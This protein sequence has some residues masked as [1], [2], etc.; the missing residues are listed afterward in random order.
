M[1]DFYGPNLLPGEGHHFAEIPRGDEFHGNGPEHR[2]QR[3]VKGSG[4]AS[5]LK[6]PKNAVA[7]FFAAALLD[8]G[9]NYCADAAQMRFTI[10]FLVRRCDKVRIFLTGSFCDDDQGAKATISL[11][12]AYDLGDFFKIKRKRPPLSSTSPGNL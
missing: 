3:T 9:G 11:P 4:R 2:A 12:F 5:A 7:R 8:L 10:S 1:G 6:V